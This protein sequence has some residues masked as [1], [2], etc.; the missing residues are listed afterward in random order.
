[1]TTAADATDRVGK[2][3]MRVV[4]AERTPE[5]EERWARRSEAL[6]AWLLARWRQQQQLHQK[7]AC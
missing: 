6:A 1:M 4:P 7:E 5:S 3:A 2:F